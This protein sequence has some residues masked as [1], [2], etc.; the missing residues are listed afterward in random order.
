MEGN[1]AN[2]RGLFRPARATVG[3]GRRKFFALFGGVIAWP[4]ATRAQQGG[5]VQRIGVLIPF[6]EG[7]TE[8]QARLKAFE[9]ELHKL[10]YAEG[11]N[12]R[13]DRRFAGGEPD[14]LRAF[15]KA[16]VDLQPDAILSHSTPATAALLQQTRS[17]PIVFAN[18]S[19]PVGS[20]FIE[21]LA[22]PGGN[23][24][25]FTNFEDSLI[26]KWLELLKEVAP[27]TMR[28]GL[29]YNPDTAPQA[30]YYL[31]LF[32]PAAGALGVQ[33]IRARVGHVTEIEAAM[34]ALSRETNGGLVVMPDNFTNVHRKLIISL[35]ARHRVPTIYPYRYMAADGGLLAYGVD[36]TDAYR[37]AASY[38][39]R[40]LRGER[41]ANLPVQAPTRFELI[42][43]LKTA[44]SLG[45]E[46][47]PTVLGRADEVI[48]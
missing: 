9:H 20:G 17:I 12:L 29:I 15:A 13:I 1:M 16:L 32:E 24:T 27:H 28:V 10:G 22:H 31:R 36:Q 34:I 18:L 26:G 5:S 37:R 35:A 6:A 38:I 8:S 46:I 3:V 25:G 44:K 2:T 45:I 30:D 4:L 41:P 7:D 42:V 14:R 40:I 11:R 23:A 47:P 39:D 48:E 19:D 33:P 21:S 43:N